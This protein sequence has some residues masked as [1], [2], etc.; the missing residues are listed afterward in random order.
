MPAVDQA[1][2]PRAPAACGCSGSRAAPVRRLPPDDGRR[3]VRD[4]GGKAKPRGLNTRRRPP[5]A[6][7]CDRSHHNARR[8]SLKAGGHRQAADSLS[9]QTCSWHKHVHEYPHRASAPCPPHAPNGHPAGRRK[10]VGLRVVASPAQATA[11]APASCPRTS[12][13]T[14]GA[15]RSCTI[16]RLMRSPLGPRSVSAR[17]ER[18]SR[19]AH[20]L[21]D[22]GLSLTRQPVGGTPADPLAEGKASERASARVAA[23]ASRATVGTTAAIVSWPARVS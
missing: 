5:P 11:S 7:T 21:G 4:I 12:R 19:T 20:S 18:S 17:P 3:K 1:E 23:T 14:N 2:Q 22:R 9:P 10:P 13:L 6:L 16:P 8:R 15:D